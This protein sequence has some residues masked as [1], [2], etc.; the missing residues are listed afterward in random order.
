MSWVTDALTRTQNLTAPSKPAVE[1][2]PTPRWRAQWRQLTAVLERDTL[3]FNESRKAQYMFSSGEVM[4]QV[5]PKQPPMDGAVLEIDPRNGTIRVTC[6]IDHPGVPR[7]GTFKLVSG[8]IVAGAG[9]V[10]KPEPPTEPMT[11]EAF[12]EFILKPIFFP[13]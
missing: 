5:I 6:T 7:R 8:G 2:E 11:F 1:F 12:S 13:S 10:G 9:F 4:I 3:E